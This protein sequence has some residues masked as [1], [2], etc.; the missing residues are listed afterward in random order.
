MCVTI[1]QN[2]MVLILGTNYS[3]GL[4]REMCYGIYGVN[5]SRQN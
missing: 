3:V 2:V 5:L 4:W 1:G